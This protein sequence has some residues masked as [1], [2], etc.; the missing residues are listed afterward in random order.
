MMEGN[1]TRMMNGQIFVPAGQIV[2]LGPILKMIRRR[3]S[4]NVPQR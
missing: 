3:E 1:S 4:G 2:D